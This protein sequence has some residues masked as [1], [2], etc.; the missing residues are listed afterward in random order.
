[1][2]LNK[3]EKRLSDGTWSIYL[4]SENGNN[5]TEKGYSEY[6]FSFNGEGG[7]SAR[8]PSLG[9][10]IIGIYEMKVINKQP[11]MR[12]TM[13]NPLESL[14]EEWEIVEQHKTKVE[15][16]ANSF[17]TKRLVFLKDK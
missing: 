1:M 5:L 4:Y 13:Y 3:T 2:T 6:T 10:N 17:K 16:R 7:M 14:N 12:I 15:L 9:V 11:I 8:I